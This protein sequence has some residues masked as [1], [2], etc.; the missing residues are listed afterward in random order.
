MESIISIEIIVTIMLKRIKNGGPRPP[1]WYWL[2]AASYWRISTSLV[3][4]RNS[5]PIKKH[6]TATPIGYHRP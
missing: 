6:T 5:R 1:F 3:S 2:Y 4:R